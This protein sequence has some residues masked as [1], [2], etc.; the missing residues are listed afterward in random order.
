M[1]LNIVWP[2]ALTS[3]RATYFNYG[4]V[5]LVIMV[6]IVAIGAIYEAIARPD[7]K[8]PLQTNL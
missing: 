5:T 2:S 6:V 3:G 8:M 4:W 7:K 1:L